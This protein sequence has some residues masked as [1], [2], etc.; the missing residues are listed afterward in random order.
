MGLEGIAKFVLII[1]A[2][3]VVIGLLLLLA[4]KMP[5]LGKLPGDII[6]RRDNFVF[7]SPLVTCLVVSIVATIVLNL[8]LW[9][10]RR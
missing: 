3:I 5:F 6:T 7:S 1:G 9:L 2:V 4:S 10:M 8:I